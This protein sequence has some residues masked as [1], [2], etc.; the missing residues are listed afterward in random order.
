VHSKIPLK[1]LSRRWISMRQKDT[2]GAIQVAMKRWKNRGVKDFSHSHTHFH[3]HFHF[4]CSVGLSLAA[5]FALFCSINE[6]AHKLHGTYFAPCK[7]TCGHLKCKKAFTMPL[8]LQYLAELNIKPT[9]TGTRAIDS[10]QLSKGRKTETTT[11]FHTFIWVGGCVLL[12]HG[13]CL[14]PKANIYK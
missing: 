4:H 10:C 3:S 9:K 2:G 11:N 7:W 13:P 12:V 5:I 14:G 6:A 8:Q 1:A